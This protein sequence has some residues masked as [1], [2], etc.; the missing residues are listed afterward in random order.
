MHPVGRVDQ[1]V[2]LSSV[3]TLYP[4]HGALRTGTLR[5]PEGQTELKSLVCKKI[6]PVVVLK[7]E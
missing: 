3:F 7:V 5:G 4:G 6:F 2:A 1:D